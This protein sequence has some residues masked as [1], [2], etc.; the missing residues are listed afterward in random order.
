MSASSIIVKA[1]AA[2]IGCVLLA[3]TAVPGHTQ[4]YRK[5]QVQDRV[6]DTNQRINQEYSEGDISRGLERRLG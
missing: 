5:D 2:T 6:Q 4:E 3:A 1:A